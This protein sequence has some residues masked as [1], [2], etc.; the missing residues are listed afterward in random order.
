VGQRR[1]LDPGRYGMTAGVEPIPFWH[2][3]LA[4]SYAGDWVLRVAGRLKVV[5]VD[6][7][8]VGTLGVAG[9]R[10]VRN[11][12]GAHAPGVVHHRARESPR[13]G[14]CPGR[15]TAGGHRQTGN[16]A[17]G[18]P[19]DVLTEAIHPEPRF[20][21]VGPNVTVTPPQPERTRNSTNGRPGWREDCPDESG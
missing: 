5:P 1:L 20:Y 10:K 14:T 16:R 3:W 8:G 15:G 13:W 11:P 6:A 12:V 21:V 7:E 18:D 4:D 17:Q 9:I 2:V 19:G